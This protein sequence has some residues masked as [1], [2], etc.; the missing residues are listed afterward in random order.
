METIKSPIE[1]DLENLKAAMIK[2]G[3]DMMSLIRNGFTSLCKLNGE[4]AR[5][6]IEADRA[7]DLQENEIDKKVVTLVGLRQPVAKD[8]R[9]LTSIVKTCAFYERMADQ[10]VNLAQRAEGLVEV[11]ADQPPDEI[12]EIF[13]VT[14]GMVEQCVLVFE[15]ADPAKAR[16]IIQ[17]DEEVDFLTR[18]FLESSILAMQDGTMEVETGV[19]LILASRHLE[20][21][22]DLAC[23]VAESVIYSAEGEVVRHKPVS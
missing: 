10:G 6:A 22:A 20:R 21:I 15:Q 12:C 11:K 5:K 2:M 1:V 3:G 13:D 19:E 18:R 16:T 17:Q 4:M 8:L 23:N 7:I 14:I 9:F